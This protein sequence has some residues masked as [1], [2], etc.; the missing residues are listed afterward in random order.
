MSSGADAAWRMSLRT[1]FE[2]A[3]RMGIMIVKT[4][5]YRIYLIA[6]VPA[7]SKLNLHSRKRCHAVMDAI[8]RVRMK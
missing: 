5:I 4:V 7:E 8:S 1:I 2:P 6:F 3:R